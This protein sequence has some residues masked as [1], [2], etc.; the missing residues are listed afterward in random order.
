MQIIFCG[1]FGWFIY[2]NFGSVRKLLVLN[3]SMYEML[4]ILTN[5]NFNHAAKCKYCGAACVVLAVLP[6]G[7]FYQCV[8]DPSVCRGFE[9]PHTNNIYLGRTATPS[10]CSF[11]EFF[12][13]CYIIKMIVWD[14][15]TV[16]RHCFFLYCGYRAAEIVLHGHVHRGFVLNNKMWCD[17]YSLFIQTV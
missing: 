2:C 7:H 5:F 9:K 12:D 10:Q 14:N 17:G 4:N 3:V 16:C 6:H 1:K 13:I 11:T 8:S 15:G